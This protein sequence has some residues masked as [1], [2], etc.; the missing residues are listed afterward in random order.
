MWLYDAASPTENKKE[1][2][3]DQEKDENNKLLKNLSEQKDNGLF[4]FPPLKDQNMIPSD[5]NAET[6]SEH[7]DTFNLS[8]MPS[9]SNQPLQSSY[10]SWNTRNL[11]QRNTQ[12]T[13]SERNTS[14]SS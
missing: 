4:N 9:F 13:S 11:S 14:N 12:T 2:F 5:N 7:Q 10:S 1:S 6:F 8:F 3:S